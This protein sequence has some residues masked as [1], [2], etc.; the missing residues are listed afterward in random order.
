VVIVEFILVVISVIAIAVEF[1]L[2]RPKTEK[3]IV[4]VIS[5]ILVAVFGIYPLLEPEE[6]E[7]EIEE[8]SVVHHE[9][10]QKGI[11]RTYKELTF[12][13]GS[14]MLDYYD[15][16]LS[17]PR[18]L[19]PFKNREYDYPIEIW[20]D[21]TGQ[22]LISL[23]VRSIDGKIAGEL[24]DNELVEN[25][26]NYFDRNYT[27]YGVEV[28]DKDLRP[29]F[30]I[31]IDETGLVYIYGVFYV[32]KD[33]EYLIV[34]ISGSS[35]IIGDYK[36]IREEI[37]SRINIRAFEYPSSTNLGILRQEQ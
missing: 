23:I 35:Y 18:L 21:E 16:D 4:C 36:L 20:V 1:R 22:L 12:R 31:R 5:G 14:D 30:Q 7:V 28:V 27:K 19:Q 15:V 33:G 24:F 34:F 17:Y 9:I 3:I 8:T 13:M 37:E 11:P 6:G 29:V 32:E 10:L 26:N 25:P 2:K